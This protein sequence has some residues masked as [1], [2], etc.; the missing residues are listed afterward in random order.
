MFLLCPS[1]K[2]HHP[3]NPF[4]PLREMTNKKR[5]KTILQSVNF[6]LHAN[7]F[8]ILLSLATTAG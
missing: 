7:Y 5:K 3:F 4:L 2:V 6:N 1:S 8:V